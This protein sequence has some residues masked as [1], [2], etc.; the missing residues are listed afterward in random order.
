M[1]NTEHFL[2][3]SK[4][5]VALAVG[6]TMLA[7]NY[8]GWAIAQA[9]ASDV[10][11]PAAVLMCWVIGRKATSVKHA[12]THSALRSKLRHVRTGRK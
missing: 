4:V 7:I 6:S 10:L 8:G 2:L 12:A 3:L 9:I 11:F 1:I 5:G